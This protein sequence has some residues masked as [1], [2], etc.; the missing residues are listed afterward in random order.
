VTVPTYQYVCRSCETPLEVVQTFTEPAL[1]DCPNCEGGQLRKVFNSVGVVFKGSGFYR[2]DSRTDS[3]S[4]SA[5]STTASTP[6]KGEGSSDGKAAKKDADSG[7]TT[8]SSTSTS[9]AATPAA[10][11]SGGESK[12]QPAK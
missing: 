12:S 2:T 1:T 6:G 9:S 5:K 4:T 10:S 11:K 3:G 7:A 8:A